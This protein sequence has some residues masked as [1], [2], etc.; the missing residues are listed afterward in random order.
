LS[1]TEA[2]VWRASC[3]RIPLKI[4]DY[5]DIKVLTLQALTS[6]KPVHLLYTGIPG[7]AK[8]IFLLEL[9]H[10]GCTDVLGSQAT[11][12]GMADLL[13]NAL[14][15]ILLVDE[16]DR[17]GTKDIAVLLSLAQTGIVP[18]TKHGK[19]REV[20]LRTKIFVASNST[21]MPL[22][23]LSRFMV[24]Q[25]KPYSREDFLIIATNVLRKRAGLE[26]ELVAYIAGKV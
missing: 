14:P 5:D 13:F 3:N 19:T 23:L 11:K 17:I 9:S 1:I 18:E 2:W 24:L 22:E 15:E 25:F 20:K 6:D 26:P 7:S 4:E 8:T 12:S 16:I 21:K 10:L